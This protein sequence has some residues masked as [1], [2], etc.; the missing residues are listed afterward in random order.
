MSNEPYLSVEIIK[1]TKG[2]EDLPEGTKSGDVK[3]VKNENGAVV[4]VRWLPQN[5]PVKYRPTG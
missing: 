3:V 1:S 5:R 4:A 2:R